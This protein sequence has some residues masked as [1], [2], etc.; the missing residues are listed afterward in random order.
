[1]KEIKSVEEWCE[2][3]FKS[4]SNILIVV[5]FTAPWCG[6]CRSFAPIFEGVSQ[7]DIHTDVIFCKV[8]VDEVGE[9]AQQYGIMS[10]PTIL[11]IKAGEVLGKQSGTT[12]AFTFSEKVKE[13][14]TI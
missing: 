11:F 12:N 7:E 10:I 3:I 9:I 6:P 4:S 13:F 2:L 1:M 14:N 8:N 5:D